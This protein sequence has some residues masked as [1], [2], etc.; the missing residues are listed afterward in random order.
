MRVTLLLLVC[1]IAKSFW[2][3][4]SWDV[5][6]SFVA[7]TLGLQKYLCASTAFDKIMVEKL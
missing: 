5:V 3:K 6:I 4:R 1:S 7:S 2:R